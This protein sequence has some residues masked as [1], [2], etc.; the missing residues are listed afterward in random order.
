[1]N[2]GNNDNKMKDTPFVSV[3]VPNYNHAKFLR[4]RLDSIL[5]QTYTH[6][7]LIILDDCSTDNSMDVIDQ[8]K[9]EP[10]LKMV[11]RNEQNSGSPFKQWNKGIVL[12][13]G[14]LIWIAESD[15][16]CSPDF[17]ETM[18]KKH[19]EHPEAVI[20]FCRSQMIDE[21][22]EKNGGF[23]CTKRFRDFY[24]G[25]EFIDNFLMWHND[26]T[27]A[28]SVLFKREEALHISGDYMNYRSS[29]D[30][31]FW[32]LLCEKGGVAF[33]D[34]PMN[35]HRIHGDNT[36]STNFLSGSSYK[37]DVQILK[38][39]EAHHLISKWNAFRVK[40]Y[41]VTFI[42]YRDEIFKGNKALQDEI[43]S[44]WNPSVLVKLASWISNRLNK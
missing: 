35:Y 8:Y 34:F 6:F 44:E 38:Y 3:I 28:S 27:N 42:K 31:L 43:L 2:V 13:Q 39:L 1:M 29:G 21:N 15:D 32:I 11:V 7:E 10:R 12:A 40:K 33:E 37:Q 23:T 17:L 5:K 16:A 18:V 14:D 24:T 26:I 30:R 19:L 36:T 22:G 9:D 41:N 4:E 25:R 20:A